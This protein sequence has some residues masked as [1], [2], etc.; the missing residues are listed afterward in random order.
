MHFFQRKAQA[1]LEYMALFALMSVVLLTASYYLYS[2]FQVQSRAFQARIAV[3]QIASAADAVAS[4]GIGS[5]KQVSAYFPSGLINAT[6]RGR[7][8]LLV[9]PGSDGRPNDVYAFTLANL[10]AYQFPLVEGRHTFN[11]AFNANGNVSISG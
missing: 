6:G 10:S 11:V 7:E 3:D 8:I 9:I 1:S 4:Q 5:S 2:N